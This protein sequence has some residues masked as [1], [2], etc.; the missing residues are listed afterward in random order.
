MNEQRKDD[1]LDS[2]KESLQQALRDFGP[3]PL[4]QQGLVYSPN[5]GHKYSIDREDVPLPQIP[6]MALLLLSCHNLGPGEKLKWEISFTYRGVACSLALQKFGLRLYISSDAVESDEE[7]AKMAKLIIGKLKKSQKVLERTL[8]R[9]LG[10]EQLRLG[11]VTIG[12]QYHQLRMT[13]SYFRESASLAFAQ[14]GRLKGKLTFHASGSTDQS[15]EELHDTLQR[16]TDGQAAEREGFYNTLAMVSSFFSLLEHTLVL[17]LPF[18]GFDSASEDLAKFIGDRW[19]QKLQRVFD[20]NSDAVAKRHYD[21]LHRISEDYRNT[22]G[23]GGFDKFPHAT[24]A[25]HVPGLGALPVKLSDVRDSPHFAF[26]PVDAT[27]FEDICATFDGFESHL[28]DAPTKFAMMWIEEGLDVSYDSDFRQRMA[29]AMTS[30]D[31]F[32]GMVY[33]ASGALDDYINN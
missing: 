8:L 12:N 17:V 30:D 29:S 23:H 6:M 5:G 31:D 25:F 21:A 3:N 24:I 26:A 1:L 32:M 13:Y 2:V 27:K 20:L 9:D 11:Q 4:D 33:S 19:A 28:K 14:K 15:V 16:I 22:Y 7:A 18:I 10:A